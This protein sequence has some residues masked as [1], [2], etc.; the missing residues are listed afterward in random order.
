MMATVSILLVRFQITL[1]PILAFLTFVAYRIH[2]VSRAT[3]GN[4]KELLPPLLI[5]VGLIAMHRARRFEQLQLQKL[6]SS[7]STSTATTTTTYTPA[8]AFWSFWFGESL[9]ITIFSLN[10]MT[11]FEHF[12]KS[13]LMMALSVGGVAL[14]VAFWL[15]GSIWNYATI[16]GLEVIVGALV[17]LAFPIMEVLLENIIN[18]KLRRVGEKVRAHHQ[19]LE[20]YYQNKMMMTMAT[21]TNQKR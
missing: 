12:H 15:R 3:G 18:D 1:Y 11:T 2:V 6:S 17:A 13:F 14:V 16:L 5:A 7:S 21:K 19:Q 10:S 4:I 20:A 9:V 8:K